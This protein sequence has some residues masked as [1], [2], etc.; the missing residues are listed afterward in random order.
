[1]V[2]GVSSVTYGSILMAAAVGL[3]TTVAI[4]QAGSFKKEYKLQ[5]NV[6]PSFYWGMG[7]SR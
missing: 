6:G 3:C 7:A 5:V 1:M 4:A 2:R